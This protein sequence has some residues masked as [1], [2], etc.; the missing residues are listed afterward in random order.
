ME[1]GRRLL[2]MKRS[3][4][5]R[6]PGFIYHLG[7]Q[8]CLPVCLLVPRAGNQRN[9]IKILL[10]FPLTAVISSSL[11]FSACAFAALPHMRE[12][13]FQ[14]PLITRELK[15]KKGTPEI[16]QR[17]L[18]YLDHGRLKNWLMHASSFKYSRPIIERA[19]FSLYVL[20]RNS[21]YGMI[22]VH[23]KPLSNNP[24]LSYSFFL[25]GFR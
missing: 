4:P 22:E 9:Y 18:R 25:L 19:G 8:V 24:P 17:A 23:S 16:I 3:S 5:M 6:E 13:E 12:W 10:Y 2:N 7:L 20:M 11:Y 14:T 15:A 1:E 21:Q